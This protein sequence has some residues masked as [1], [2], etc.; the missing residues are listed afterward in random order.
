ML[1]QNNNNDAVMSANVKHRKVY[2]A[3]ATTP[4]P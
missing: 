1:N 4:L 3:I 2:V